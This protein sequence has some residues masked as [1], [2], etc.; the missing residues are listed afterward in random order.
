MFG[1]FPEKRDGSEFQDSEAKRLRLDDGIDVGPGEIRI[2]QQFVGWLKG[3]GGAQIREI[4]VRSGAQVSIDQTTKDLGYSRVMLAGSAECVQSAH[5]I[6]TDELRRVMERDGLNSTVAPILSPGEEVAEATIPQKYVGWLKGSGGSQI[7]DMEARTGARIRIDQ[8]TRE[9]GYSIAQITGPPDA[10]RQCKAFVEAEVVRVQERDRVVAEH[11]AAPNLFRPAGFNE[12]QIPQQYVGWIKGSGGAQI[13]DIEA[14]TGAHITVDQSTQDMGYSRAMVYGPDEAVLAAKQ[15]IQSELSRVMERDRAV[16]GSAS[17][18][19]VPAPQPQNPQRDAL[20]LLTTLLAAASAAGGSTPAQTNVLGDALSLLS[21]AGVAGAAASAAPAV[22]PLEP[23]DTGE[24]DTVHIPN[25][26]VGWLKGRQ[27]AMIREIESRSGA[28][29]DIDQTTK[30][31]GYSIA[32]MRGRLQQK[33][34]AHGLVVAEVMKVMDQSN[35]PAVGN[36]PGAK[37]EFRIDVQYVGWVKGPRGKVVQDIQ[38]KSGTRI[39][40]DQNTRDLGY[41]VVKVYGTVEGVRSARTL[42]ATELSKISPE[43][44]ATLVDDVPGGLELA[45]Q[46]HNSHV[47][48]QIAHQSYQQQAQFGQL[49]YGVQALAPQA[50]APQLDLLGQFAQPSLAGNTLQQQAGN[51]QAAAAALQLITSLQQLASVV[52]QAPR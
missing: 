13:K 45:Q 7:R 3:K 15:I 8:S 27:G 40:V 29:V 46:A 12:V 37:S 21:G 38:V 26:C 24:W 16:P 47:Q 31:L 42:I 34:I 23:G 4:E 5:D 41:A 19:L 22:M 44:A 48:Q 25:S 11:T 1:M 43:V 33:K 30:D 9:S 17:T 28:Q 14:R 50:P 2:P 36:F 35:E 20:T 10:V 39:D 49:G 32:Q 51:L 6:I 52:S 18:A